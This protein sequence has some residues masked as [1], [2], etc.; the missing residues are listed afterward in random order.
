MTVK[1]ILMGQTYTDAKDKKQY[2]WM[3]STGW[4][5]WNKDNELVEVYGTKQVAEWS[6]K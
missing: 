4:A 5:V 6:I 2:V 3:G 1:K